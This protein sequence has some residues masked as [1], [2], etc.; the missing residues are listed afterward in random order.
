MWG[1]AQDTMPPSCNVRNIWQL[2]RFFVKTGMCLYCNFSLRNL[3]TLGS[4][5]HNCLLRGVFVTQLNDV[6]IK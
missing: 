2:L 6:N 3:E 5:P 4:L 1:M